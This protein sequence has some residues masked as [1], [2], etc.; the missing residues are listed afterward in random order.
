MIKLCLHATCVAVAGRAVLLVGASGSGK[1]DVALRMIEIGGVLVSD[2]QTEIGLENGVLTAR[3]PKAIEGIIE[4]RH[5]GLL[6]VH[7][8]PSAAVALYVELVPEGTPLERMPGSAT[9]SLLDMPVRCLK[10]VGTQASTP[11][12]IALALRGQSET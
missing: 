7:F 11:A 1:S 10:L 6:R 12:K 3:P 5:V 9:H 4:A 8:M 2:D